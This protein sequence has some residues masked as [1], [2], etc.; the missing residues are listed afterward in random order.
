METTEA[1]QSEYLTG[2]SCC[3]NHRNNPSIRWSKST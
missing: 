1:V 2:I 3:W